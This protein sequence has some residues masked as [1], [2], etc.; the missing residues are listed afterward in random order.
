MR[1]Y[2][3]SIFS[4][5]LYAGVISIAIVLLTMA[6]VWFLKFKL[7]NP[8]YW[9]LVAALLVGPWVEEL[10][11]AYN[12]DRLCRKDAGVFIN[13]TVEVEGF[14]DDTSGWGPRQLSESKYR[15]MESR[16]ILSHK[17]LRVERTDDESRDRALKWYSEKNPGQQRSS[18]QFIAHPLNDKEQVVVSPNGIDAWRVVTIDKP[19]A[20]YQYKTINSHT[21]VAH[22]IK[23]FEDIV[24][25]SQS[26]EV[27]G[28]FVN[29][30]RGAY[31]FFISLAAPTIPCREAE[32]A[33]RER[34]TLSIFAF[35]L[36]PVKK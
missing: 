4:V 3:F 14:Y 16:D 34:G 2:Y 23:R 35:T 12:F 10:W 26:G 7:R 5:M 30:Y 31:W 19:T 27:L 33:V 22:Q 25:D 1:F 36:L 29:Y 24:F 9:I 15:F 6:W 8:L 11:I 32:T 13:K 21:S 28:R 20:R 17:L 18:E